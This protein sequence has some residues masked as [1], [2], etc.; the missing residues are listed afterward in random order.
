[1]KKS[2]LYII[3]FSIGIMAYADNTNADYISETGYIQN[4][5]AG[6]ISGGGT[7]AVESMP[8]ANNIW[9]KWFSNG[10]Y[11]I[12]GG[13]STTLGKEGVQTQVG[14]FN[15]TSVYGVN[16]FGQTG[17]VAGFA[18]GGGFTVMNP[19]FADQMNGSNVNASLLTPTNRQIALTQAFAE[20]Q[21]ESTLNIDAGLIAINNNPWLP[22]SYFNNSVNVPVTY[23][24]LLT[25]VYVG[26]GWLLTALAFNGIQTS[27]QNGFTN[28]T[29]LNSAYGVNYQT[30]NTPSNYTMAVGANFI[31]NDSLYN[32]RLWAYQFDNYGTLLYGD[33]TVRFAFNDTVSMNF[34]L[35]AGVD[36]N[37]GGNNAYSNYPYNSYLAAT[38]I[39]SNFVGV[40][41]GITVDWF[42]FN[43]SGNSI[44]GPSSAIG[45]GA[46][47]SPYTANLAA[48][49]LYAEGWQTSMVNSGITG[50]VYKIGSTLTFLDNSLSISPNYVTISNMN[51]EWNGTQEAFITVNY[52]IPQVKGLTVFGAYSYQWLPIAN[53]SQNDWTSQLLVSYLW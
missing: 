15:N 7:L 42:N 22:G 31:T 35:Q 11:N 20:Y 26:G 43:L 9:E 53:P 41:A 1:M 40:Q 2:L 25:N 46:I 44:W 3:L 48:D 32:L 5:Y 47:V 50:N 45:S 16:A 51:P 28:E 21:Y 49:P 6:I 36:N 38:D 29:L 34:G 24:G 30:N 12:Y 4:P 18:F 39:N 27:G 52:A 37:F 23:Q 13:A 19:F 17:H 33:N 8:V 14:T 10:T